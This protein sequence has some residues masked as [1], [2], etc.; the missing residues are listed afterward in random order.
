MADNLQG[1]GQNGNDQNG[2]DKKKATG[3]TLKCACEFPRVYRG[4]DGRENGTIKKVMRTEFLMTTDGAEVS[5]SLGVW[6][7]LN[8]GP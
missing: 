6:G 2:S 7:A 4:K 1:P 8:L 3:V 5:I